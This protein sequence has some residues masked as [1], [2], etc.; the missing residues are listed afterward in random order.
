MKL[1]KIEGG[2]GGKKGHSNMSHWA[3]TEEIKKAAKRQRRKLDKKLEKG[4]E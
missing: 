2:Q 1:K 3:Y 4:A